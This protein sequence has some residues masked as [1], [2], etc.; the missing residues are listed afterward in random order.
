[1]LAA[2]PL[3]LKYNLATTLKRKIMLFLTAFKSFSTCTT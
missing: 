3:K 2:N 1:M